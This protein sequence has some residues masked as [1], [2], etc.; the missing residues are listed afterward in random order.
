MTLPKITNDWT[1]IGASDRRLELFENSY[2]LPRGVSYNSYLLKDEKTVL[3]DTA[4][5]AVREV[6]LDNLKTA[7]EGR[8][9]DYFVIEHMEPDHGA[10]IAEICEKYPTAQLV[11]NQKIATMIE[12]FFGL[13]ISERALIV[14]EG[15]TLN[16]GK[17]TL[18]FVMAPMVHWPEVM[19]VYDSTEKILFSADGFGSFGALDGVLYAD[20]VDYENEWL[21][22]ARRYYANIVGKYGM[23][24]QTVLKKAAG[25]DIQMICPLHG[26]I[27]RKDL[28]WFIDKYQ[29]WSTY[30]PEEKGVLIVTGS[31]YGHTQAVAD[32]LAM[33]LTEKGQKNVRVYDAAKTH[34]S[35]L[36]S[37][38]F[39]V[40]TVVLAAATYNGGVFAPMETFLNEIKAHTVAKRTFGF[41]ENGS[42]APSAKNFMQGI[43]SSLKET[44]F[45]EE[46]LL[47]KSAFKGEQLPDLE[48]M[49]DSIVRVS[50]E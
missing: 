11:V 34:S 29:K 35:D 13:D 49:A 47:I 28:G 2:P 36:L 7:L 5:N 32:K 19:M 42:W 12:Q 8:N 30:T 1:Y 37:E 48:R 24:V 4:D 16:T 40:G 10:L 6:F 46:S 21:A 9:L 3:M 20:E 50:M 27:W 15:D 14:K 31:I 23:P 18:S 44:V 45:L 25:L 17:H 43:L 26:L 38:V 33:M 41:I 22:E 39:R